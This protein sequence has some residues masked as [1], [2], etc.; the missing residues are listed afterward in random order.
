MADNPPSSPVDLA[1]SAVPTPPP[2]GPP[3]NPAWPS[4]P[5]IPSG[6]PGS[7]SAIETKS[8][9]VAPD[10]V[11]AVASLLANQFDELNK[12]LAQSIGLLRIEN[13]AED[14]V[15]VPMARAWNRLALEDPQSYVAQIRH[16]LQSLKTVIAQLHEAATKYRLIDDKNADIFKDR[17]VA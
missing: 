6:K 12:E 15:S 3:G 13:A 4:N 11:I 7:F 14:L 17:K 16:Y 1:A 9:E 5:M 2:S 10:Q 8:F